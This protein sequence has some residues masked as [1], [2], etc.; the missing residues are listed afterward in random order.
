MDVQRL[1]IE[2]ADML[3]AYFALS[4]TSE[5]DEQ[6]RSLLSSLESLHE[7]ASE[8]LADDQYALSQLHGIQQRPRSQ[9]RRE[10]LQTELRQVLA[11]NPDLAAR[12]TD[13]VRR[14]QSVLSAQN[15][16]VIDEVAPFVI[17]T[18]HH[19]TYLIYPDPDKGPEDYGPFKKW[20]D[21]Y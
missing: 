18:P 4:Q 12:V 16:I 7:V 2:A 13:L 3:A 9:S 1:S 14:V 20:A 8:G 6:Q 17:K 11:D 15:V 5:G 21:G 19:T 10:N